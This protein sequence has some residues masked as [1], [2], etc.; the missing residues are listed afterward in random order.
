MSYFM[1]LDETQ[2]YEHNSPISLFCATQG[3]QGS[4]S[5]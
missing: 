3:T 5:I 1:D 2:V 4:M